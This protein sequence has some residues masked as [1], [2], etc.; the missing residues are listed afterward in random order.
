MR[1]VN[2]TNQFTSQ[3]VNMTS[4]CD[5]ATRRNLIRTLLSLLLLLA[6]LT[7]S[8]AWAASFGVSCTD[9]NN[10]SLANCTI[11]SGA[12]SLDFIQT[13]R[14]V[15][16]NLQQGA[17][18]DALCQRSGDVI[19]CVIS[20]SRPGLNPVVLRCERTGETA[21]D[22][23]LAGL[24]R[25][26]LSMSCSY[27]GNSG[28]CSLETNAAGVRDDLQNRNINLSLAGSSIGTNLL[29]RCAARAGT[30]SF[31]QCD[32][33]LGALINGNN[34]AARALIEAIAPQNADLAMD[35]S[36]QQTGSQST[37][38]NARMKRLRGNQPQAR[39]LDTSGLQFSDGTQWVN[40]GTLLASNETGTA[41]DASPN[42]SFAD[43]RLGVFIDGTLLRGEQGADA[44]E[45][46]SEQNSNMMVMGMDYRI[47][48]SWIAGVAY[49]FTLTDVTLDDD[50]GEMD[51]QG[52]ALLSYVTYY[53]DNWYIDATTGVGSD[54]Y[55]QRRRIAC[56]TDC[57][58]AFDVT[59]KANYHGEQWATT[60]GTGYDFILQSLR[61]TPN[62][63]L[64]LVRFRTNGYSE[65]SGNAAADGSGFLL[66]V[67]NQSQNITELK[68]GVSMSYAISTGFG[69]V[70]PYATVD[71]HRELNVDSL[72]INGQFVGDASNNEDFLLSTRALDDTFFILGGGISMQLQSGN[73]AFAQIRS[74]Q[75]FDNRD[76]FEFTAAWRWEL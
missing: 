26:Y 11:E 42:V 32:L 64:D 27:S 7:G 52:Y 65:T 15:L 38:L 25:D 4:G 33:L 75:G 72:Q 45:G 39:G 6:C 3:N 1:N 70:L 28:S 47:T 73:S 9:I 36:A 67:G 34:S 57:P 10:P 21:A 37:A 60:V 54:N 31:R 13:I 5:I 23:G 2:M 74:M 53:R 35:S 12:T 76:Q 24:S 43:H 51:I 48:D 61:I 62:L 44:L 30:A 58:V 49:R 16:R 69:V 40:V 71:L 68:A 41:T 18:P 20:Q 8:Q 46:A 56:T 29:T 66:D 14:A 59:A 17:D 22:C 63:Q 19:S 50:R 55:K